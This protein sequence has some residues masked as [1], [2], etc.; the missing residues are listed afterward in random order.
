[1]LL[2]FLSVVILALISV[3]G[4]TQ[5]TGSISHIQRSFTKI[6]AYERKIPPISNT[7]K[8]LQILRP[9]LKAHDSDG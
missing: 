2:K 4:L 3:V 8:N 9:L 5:V 1:M 7:F 6:A